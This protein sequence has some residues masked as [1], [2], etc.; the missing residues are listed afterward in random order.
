MVE[1]GRLLENSVPIHQGAF[2]SRGRAFLHGPYG[3]KKGGK[4]ELVS[5]MEPVDWV[6]K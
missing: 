4:G 3:K 5:K 1:N 2:L 6:L